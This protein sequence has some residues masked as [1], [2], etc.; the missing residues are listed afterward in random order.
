MATATAS[1]QQPLSDDQLDAM[2]PAL[3]QLVRE[4][5]DIAGRAPDASVSALAG[6]LATYF[7]TPDA[8]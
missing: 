6:S 5:E 8:L 1:T 2:S 4:L 7:R 3:G